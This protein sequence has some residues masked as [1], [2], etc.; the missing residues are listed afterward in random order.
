MLR[1]GPRPPPLY[2]SDANAPWTLRSDAAAAGDGV[3]DVAADLLVEQALVGAHDR[4]G[5]AGA[6]R[7]R[8]DRK[9]LAAVLC[10]GHGRLR[11]FWAGCVSLVGKFAPLLG[12]SHTITGHFLCTEG[13]WINIF[14]RTFSRSNLEKKSEILKVR[15]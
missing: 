7:R 8:E 1:W 15:P 2:S 6:E 4:F 5:G 13:E 3:T 12:L 10:L 9:G 14:F 11:W